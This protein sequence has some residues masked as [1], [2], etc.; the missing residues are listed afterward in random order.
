MLHDFQ[1]GN[2]QLRAVTPELD[3]IPGQLHQAA[4]RV[5]LA[6]F[7]SSMTLATAVVL[8]GDLSRTLN[9]LLAVACALLATGAWTILFFWHWVA[10]GKPVRVTPLLRFF[11]R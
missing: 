1:T 11:R 6:M 8:P 2:M 10:R 5:V 9:V 3:A 4:S 7:A